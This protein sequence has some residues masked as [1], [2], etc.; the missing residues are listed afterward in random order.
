MAPSLGMSSPKLFGFSAIAGTPDEQRDYVQKRLR[1]YL[2]LM[3]GLWTFLF[4]GVGALRVF[5]EVALRELTP[6]E[7]AAWGGT[8]GALWLGV[9]ALRSPRSLSVL[10]LV[11]TASILVQAVGIAAL[12]YVA[13]A[14]FR[15]DLAALLGL[16]YFLIGRAAVVP[17]TPRRT[18][19]LGVAALVP[20][21]IAGWLLFD[22]QPVPGLAGPTTIV[23]V[24]LL[25]GTLA[26]VT[27]TT[28]SRIIY[29]LERR[30]REASRLGQYTLESQIGEGGMGAVFLAKHT[31]LRRPT[32]VK[33][34]PPERAGREAIRRFEREV[35]LTSQ[36]THPNIVAIYDYG[37]TPDGVF[38][39]A[40]EHLQGVDLQKLVDEAG[41]MPE[42]RVR[43]VMRQIADALADAHAVDLIHRDIK[44]ANVVL[45]SRGRQHDF[46]KVLDFGLVKESRPSEQ[47]SVSEST[48]AT[49][50]GTPLYLS[51]EAITGPENVD[52]RSDLYALGCV[53]YFLLVA[54]PFVKGKSLVEV[55]AAHL[56][57]KPTP[58]S[59][60]VDGVPPALEALVLAL[61][62]KEPSKRPQDAVAVLAALD[63]MTDL[64]PWTVSD[65]AA[66]WARFE[67]RTQAASAKRGLGRPAIDAR[68]PEDG[69]PPPTSRRMDIDLEHR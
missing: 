23:F 69:V 35:Q 41:P 19:A 66:E 43:H 47:G 17:S 50:L 64:P 1:A 20:L 52:A 57:E 46:A 27:S 32:A 24:S 67:E 5:T 7:V 33:L 30:V 37:R 63:A 59:Q 10:E 65:A 53:A 11:D 12:V 39:Y 18:L 49:L 40:M 58:P 8:C 4:V 13:R 31:L 14:N 22:R 34:L 42:A 48:A 60:L 36:L 54:E 51:P 2:G 15:P 44:P 68:A 25:W 55:C 21:P 9:L 29:G 6:I 61:L 56:Y 38:Y 26:I 62:E 45:Q 16:S 28:I 3:G